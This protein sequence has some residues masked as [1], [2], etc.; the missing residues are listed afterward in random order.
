MQVVLKNAVALSLVIFALMPTAPSK[1][2][3]SGVNYTPDW[4][5]LS[6]NDIPEWLKD[7]K[8]GVYTHWGIYSIPAKG[9][10]G[11]PLRNMYKRELADK[12]EV[13]DHINAKY[14]PAKNFGYKDFIPMFTAPKFDAQEWAWIMKD[15]GARF[16]GI[17]VV[18]HDGFLLW[19]S[20]VNRW[21][22]KNMGPKRDIYGEIA[23][24]VRKQGLKLAATF[25]HGRTFGFCIG[26]SLKGWTQEDK[27]NL[28]VFDPAYKDFYWHDGHSSRKEF[29][30]QWKDKILEVI[31][32]YEPDVL[33][34]DGLGSPM[35][36]D[37]P[38]ESYAREIF[39][40]YYNKMESKGKDVTVCN[41][42]TGK[43]NFPEDFGLLCYENGR[44]MQ[45]NVEPWFL[46]DRAIAYPWAYEEGKNYERDNAEYHVRSLIDVVS[47]GGIFFLSLTPKGDG[48]IPDEEKQIMRG[49]G[50]WLRVNGEAIYATRRWKTIGEGPTKVIKPKKKKNGEIT[51]GWD[52][53]KEFTPRD[54][55]FTQ[56]KDGKTVYAM[57]LSWP[58]DRKIVI[59]SLKEASQYYPGKI[60]TVSMI[61]AQQKIAWKRTAKGLEISL[62]KDKPCDYAYS[63][64]ID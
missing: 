46:I 41:K 23:Q 35:A 57:A 22:S 5:S 26:K 56:S 4:E 25:H 27:E 53:R 52:F 50:R 39:A 36:N 30:Q 2:K 40:H 62:P 59:E 42:H 55:R 32:N 6:Q 49:I 13:F 14:G 38:P 8:F 43:F 33:W 34:F 20:K 44:S 58:E 9:G 63:F 64:K 21:N 12:P 17:C 29:S 54:I 28:D 45:E 47:R 31:D 16:G 15:A 7:A 3:P 37:T 51:V 18:H 10:A 48:S 19:D 11:A 60:K 24:A 1:A 61:G